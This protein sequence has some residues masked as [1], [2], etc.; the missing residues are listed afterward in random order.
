MTRKLLL[1]TALAGSLALTACSV[2]DNDTMTLQDSCN[3]QTDLPYV[4]MWE[5]GSYLNGLPKAE[6]NTINTSTYLYYYDAIHELALMTMPDALLI[7]LVGAEGTPTG[8]MQ[9][10]LI[11]TLPFGFSEHS[12]VYRLEAPDYEFDFL[13]NGKTRH[14][15]IVFKSTSEM[16]M[17]TY[18]HT[19]TVMLTIKEVYLDGELAAGEAGYLVLGAESVTK[20]TP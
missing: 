2:D 18:L 3:T 13:C 9:P 16:E 15:R 1:M 14:M 7:Q 17:N 11:K 20:S 6:V 19:I 4:G 5:L 10:F 12:Q 8:Y